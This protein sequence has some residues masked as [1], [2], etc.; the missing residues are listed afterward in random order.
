MVLKSPWI[1]LVRCRV[2]F[3]RRSN[4]KLRTAAPAVGRIYGDRS[5]FQSLLYFQRISILSKASFPRFYLCF[6]CSSSLHN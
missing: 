4:K 2:Q 5:P 1:C 3:V 6:I